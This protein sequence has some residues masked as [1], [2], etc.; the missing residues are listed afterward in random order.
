[1]AANIQAILDLDENLDECDEEKI[2]FLID[3]MSQGKKYDGMKNAISLY[4]TFTS[5]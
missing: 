4:L 3:Q 5:P 1:M 2:K